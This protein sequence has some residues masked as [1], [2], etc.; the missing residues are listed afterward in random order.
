M[1]SIRKLLVASLAVVSVLTTA[2]VSDAAFALRAT[3]GGGAPVEGANSRTVFDNNSPTTL[4]PDIDPATGSIVT[5][6]FTI[7]S[8]G[9]TFSVQAGLTA[10][11]AGTDPS[12]AVANTTY[13]VQLV[14]GPVSTVNPATIRFEFTRDGYSNINGALEV[15]E[16]ISGTR[17]GGTSSLGSVNYRSYVNNANLGTFETSGPTDTGAGLNMSLASSVNAGRVTPGSLITSPFSITTISTFS[18]TSLGQ[19]QYTGTT[20]VAAVVPAPPA[21]LLGLLGLPGLGVALR[22]RW[23]AAATA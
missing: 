22:L 21:V 11:I 9:F 8:G 6:G 16:A 17:I 12:N 14:S 23:R 4:T 20:N 2:N 3:V 15:R 10:N 18:F 7:T 5:L 1:P 13:T 19:F